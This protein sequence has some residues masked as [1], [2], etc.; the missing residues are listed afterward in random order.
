ML[1][2]LLLCLTLPLAADGTG[3]LKAAL[4]RL[5][6]SHPVKAAVHLSEW[7][8]TVEDKQPRE[9]NSQAEFQVAEGPAGFSLTLTPPTVDRIRAEIRKPLP[10]SK[11]EQKGLRPVSALVSSFG[12]LEA[13]ELVNA[14]DALLALLD[15][16]DLKEDRADASQGTSGRLL[17]FL[18]PT[19]EESKMGA[20]AKS[21]GYLKVWLGADGAPFASLRT[22]GFEGGFMWI[23]AKV[24]QRTMR[25]YTQD[26]GR[27]VV[28]DETQ[29]NN[30]EG[31]GEKAQSKRTLKLTPL[32]E[33]VR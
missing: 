15:G 22:Q 20:K 19:E 12:S 5:R 21:T 18:L 8:R 14:S 9:Q 30:A 25:R 10:K 23:K 2:S 31:A 24:E 3:D 27:L 26:A 1:R 11:K 32:R 13:A 29:E 33:P 6:G 17:G 4:L 16:A 7:Q 28:L